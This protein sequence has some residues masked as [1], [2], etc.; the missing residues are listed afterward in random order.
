[1][2]INTEKQTTY[3]EKEERFILRFNDSE[4][5]ARIPNEIFPL[6]ITIIIANFYISRILIDGGA[7][8]TLCMQIFFEKLRLRREKLGSHEGSNPMD[9][10]DIVTCPLGYIKL[11]VTLGEGRD[12]RTIK[13]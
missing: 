13:L 1:M 8:A 12:T 5:V 2:T 11:M 6:V 9:F 4:K 10:N 7:L 3:D